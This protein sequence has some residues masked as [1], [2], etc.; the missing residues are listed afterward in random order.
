LVGQLCAQALLPNPGMMA[1]TMASAAKLRVMLMT[2]LPRRVIP[3]CGNRFS[4]KI[5]RK[6]T[7]V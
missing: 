5:T 4:E 2:L 6:T 1:S 7:P 3:K